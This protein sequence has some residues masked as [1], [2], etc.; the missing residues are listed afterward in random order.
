MYIIVVNTLQV[1][2]VRSVGTAQSIV[3]SVYLPPT[4]SSLGP[5]EKEPALRIYSEGIELLAPQPEG[6]ATHMTQALEDIAAH[7]PPLSE[8]VATHMTQGLEDGVTYLPPQSEGVATQALASHNPR[9]VCR[10]VANN[11]PLTSTTQNAVS[12]IRPVFLPLT[13]ASL[14]LLEKDCLLHAS[15]TPF[16]NERPVTRAS[17]STSTVLE[18]P[19]ERGTLRVRSGNV[20]CLPLLPDDVVAHA[21]LFLR[22]KELLLAVQNVSRQLSR[23]SARSLRL[24][25]VVYVTDNDKVRSRSCEM[26]IRQVQKM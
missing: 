16:I 14:N 3:R 24:P 6:V 15:Q 1:F 9:I 26:Y 11:S 20:A 5:P 2:G 22:V 19:D 8:G 21:F 7:L 25:R 10:T 23:C 12:N 17:P 18:L 4:K 13:K